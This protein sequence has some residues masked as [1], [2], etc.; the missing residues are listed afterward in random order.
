MDNFIEIIVPESG[1]PV[2]KA[3]I[4]L[5][6]FDGVHPGHRQVVAT[7]GKLAKELGA[8]TGA[9][10][11]IPHPRQVLGNGNG[12]K[13]LLPEAERCKALLSSGA[14]FVGKINFSA[15][16]SQ[17]DAGKFLCALRDCGLFELAGICVGSN[18]K[19]GKN[20]CGNKTVLEDFC[21]R[22]DIVFSPVEEITDDGGVISSTRL[23]KMISQG[24]LE[25]Y[26]ETS[27]NFPMLYGKVVSGMHIAGKELAAPTANLEADYGVLVPHGVYCGYS[28]VDG[29]KYLAVLNIGPAPTY[30]VEQTRV[31]IHLLGFNGTLYGRELPV[32]LVKKLRDIRKFASPQELKEQIM[33]DIASAREA[34]S[35]LANK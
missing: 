20:G 13:L 1:F 33:L 8:V 11:F 9:V 7:A 32:Y 19:F 12:F 3:V 31:E 15:E 5:G 30:N 25:Q 17:W 21:K 16:I 22:N 34:T 35:F 2:K 27:G 4:A 28:C 10:T 14:D 23:R 29:K 6:V 18:W 26:R 24:K